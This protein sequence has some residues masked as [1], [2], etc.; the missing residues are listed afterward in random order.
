ML[1]NIHTRTYADTHGIVAR[2]YGCRLPLLC[3][4]ESFARYEKYDEDEEENHKENEQLHLEVV[5]PHLS[6]EL[7]S[8]PME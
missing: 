6:S 3:A 4:L 1:Q 5:P 7:L 8:L 2:A